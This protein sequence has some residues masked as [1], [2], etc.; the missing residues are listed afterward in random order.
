MGL[1]MVMPM[2]AAHST[3]NRFRV[4][5]LAC[6][7]LCFVV[8][9]AAM[10][11]ADSWVREKG[12]RRDFPLV[13]S[14]GVANLILGADDFKVVSIA[15]ADLARDIESVTGR[16]PAIK[17]SDGTARSSEVLIG[18]LGKHAGID[19]LVAAG[20]LDVTALRDAWESFIIATVDLGPG[21]Q[22]AL[23][24][25]GSDR[26]GT[27]FGAYEL[28][29]AIGVSPWHWWADI[30]PAKRS[31]LFVAHGTRRFGPP[32]VKY[33]GIF[34]ND[35]DWGMHRWAASTFEP[36]SGGIGPKTYAKVF[37]LM[38][39]L[40][41]N[42]VWPAMHA[43]TKPFND[44][45]EHKRLADDYAIVMG[46]SHA[47]PMLRNNVGEWKA[48][49]ETYNYMTNRDGVRAYWEERVRDNGSFENIYTLGMRGIHDSNMQGPKTDP[50]R[51]RTLEQIFSDQRALLAQHVRPDVERVPQMFCA[52]K[53]VLSLYRQG[54][55]VPDDVT[56]VW[57]DDNH[58]YVRNHANATE[59]ERTGGFGVYY[60]LSYLGAPMSYLWLST[61]PPA[62]VWSE[63]SRAY[64]HGARAIWIAN[65]GDLKPA[66]I[67]TE[68]FLQMA[69][70]IKRW[71]RENLQ[72]FLV[73]WA[74]REIGVGHAKEIAS[75]LR[76]YYRLNHQRRPEHLQGWLPREEPRASPFAPTEVDARLSAF[77][78]LRKRAQ[79]VKARLPIAKR[80]AFVE[81]VGYPVEGSA[82]ANVRFFAG[83]R[84]EAARAQAADAELKQATAVFQEQVAGG[85]WRGFM[86]LEPADDQWR[87][88]RIAPWQ[89]PTYAAKPPARPETP[90]EVHSI[91][92]ERFSRKQDRDGVSWEVIP[93]L[94]RT[95][96]SISVFPT[97]AAGVDPARLLA[98]APRVEYDITFASAG[99]FEIKV[100]LMPTHGIASGSLRF[101]IAIDEGA[102]QVVSLDV[103]DGGPEWAL[104]VLNATRVASA[105]LHVPNAGRHVLRVFGVDA[106]VVVDKI[107]IHHGDLPSSYL[108]P[109]ETVR[110]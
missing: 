29:Q 75:I 69:W 32:S 102:P 7:G 76:E 2:P 63:M 3:R 92:A 30:N 91:E 20:S 46:S 77:A 21:S 23:V 33:R 70:D 6:L 9:T 16:R 34:L 83:E 103:K 57:P 101:A 79:A 106:G 48:K 98:V 51:I 67:G 80:D 31:S 27:A 42:T 107:V 64:D 50:E 55:R 61:T 8:A 39:R 58:G 10:A 54:L 14:R 74:S 100:N 95:G 65:V 81:L 56:I 41:A 71:R 40:K 105:K 72:D 24:I 66:E 13:A 93:G 52:Y 82:L 15:A 44:F 85:K 90:A 60:H 94:G 5:S 11:S 1:K 84:G 18:T 88:M 99:D 78:S 86:S 26:R 89:L 38:L 4:R 97:T 17:T 68:F 12:Q 109:P 37:E 73:E 25:A 104:G 87:S 47:E 49:P 53:E 43:V 62:L 96:D 59:R 36:E 45:A 28:S 22:G 110:R 35:E 19:A 108:G